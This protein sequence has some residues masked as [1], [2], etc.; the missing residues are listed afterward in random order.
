MWEEVEGMENASLGVGGA[1]SILSVVTK[2]STLPRG[3]V[4]SVP[5][6]GAGN[7]WLQTPETIK[8]TRFGRAD[9]HPCF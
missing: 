1:S 5:Q 9:P 2:L 7:T 3:T 4:E 6:R 8:S